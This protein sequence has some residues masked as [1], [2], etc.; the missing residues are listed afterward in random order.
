MEIKNAIIKSALGNRFINW[1][2]ILTMMVAD[3]VF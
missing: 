2:L 1:L 3:K